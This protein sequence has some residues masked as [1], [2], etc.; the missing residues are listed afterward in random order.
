M[1]VQPAITVKVSA[2]TSDFTDALDVVVR[3]LTALSADLKAL[4]NR[5]GREGD[6]P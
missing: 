6:T 5:D 2:D 1:A 3:H 4:R